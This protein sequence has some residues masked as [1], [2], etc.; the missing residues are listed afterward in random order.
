MAAQSETNCIRFFSPSERSRNISPHFM[1]GRLLHPLQFPLKYFSRIL[2]ALAVLRGNENSEKADLP[3]ICFR[4]E[5]DEAYKTEYADY[6]SNPADVRTIPIE[7]YHPVCFSFARKQITGRSIPVFPVMVDA[8]CITTIAGANR[9][10]SGL[11]KEAL[12]AKEQVRALTLV[13]QNAGCI[14]AGWKCQKD[15]R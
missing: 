13:P 14:S 12:P 3:G 1:V 7:Y 8:S 11:I 10:V 5:F 4:I 15:Q 2:P 9:Y 6:I